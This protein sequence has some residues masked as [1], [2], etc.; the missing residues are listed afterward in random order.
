M[1]TKTF[2][3]QHYQY[4]Q[5]LLAFLISFTVIS[6]V[7]INIYFPAAAAEKVAEKIVDEVL[8]ADEPNVSPETEQQMNQSKSVIDSQVIGQYKVLTVENLTQWNPLFAMLDFFIPVANA[9]E[10]NIS[11]ETAKIRSLRNSMAKRQSKLR[12]FYQSGAI[13]FTNKG[14]VASVGRSGLSVKQRSTVNKL[15]KSENKDRMALYTEIA[16]ANGHPEWKK[17]IQ[18]TFSNTWINKIKPG[19]MYQTPSGQWKKK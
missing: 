7:T 13:G 10:A 11:I 8:N 4:R 19:W 15:V 2:F 16:N 18:K 17:N 12:P 3:L 1:N 9:G 5:L 6:C 14:L